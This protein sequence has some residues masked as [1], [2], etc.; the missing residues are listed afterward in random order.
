MSQQSKQG[1]KIKTTIP[2]NFNL[3][4]SDNK[5]EIDNFIKKIENNIRNETYNFRPDVPDNTTKLNAV[6]TFVPAKVKKK[7]I[8]VIVMRV[9]V[10]VRV[11]SRIMN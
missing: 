8:I 5:K 7:K 2:A 3:I 4:S 10:R 6:V 11:K 9:R 1:Q